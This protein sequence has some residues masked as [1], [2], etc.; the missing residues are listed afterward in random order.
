MSKWLIA[1]GALVL[2]L[3]RMTKFVV[4]QTMHQ[5]ESIRV[6]NDIFRLTYLQNEGVAFGLFPEARYVFLVTTILII[7]GISALLVFKKI[8]TDRWLSLAFGLILGGATGNLWDRL[9]YGAVIDFLDIGLKSYR[10]PAF[11]LADSAICLGVLMILYST[12]KERKD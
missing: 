2:G 12:L 10:W 9:G 8:K 3:D 7:L 11:N 6:W 1:P 4:Y 5:G